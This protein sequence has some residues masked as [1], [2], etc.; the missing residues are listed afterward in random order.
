MQLATFTNNFYKISKLNLT[1]IHI[2]KNKICISFTLF[3]EIT[4]NFIILLP[5]KFVDWKSLKFNVKMFAVC[6]ITQPVWTLFL[7]KY[8]W[9]R[10][11]GSQGCQKIRFLLQIK[12]LR[13][14]AKIAQK[15]HKLQKIVKIEKKM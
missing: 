15:R 12:K 1:F 3:I 2:Y 9:T 13:S 10:S 7:F 11:Q 4:G 5:W 8:I 6:S 14:C